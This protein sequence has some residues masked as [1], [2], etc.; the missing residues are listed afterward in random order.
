ME[1]ETTAKLERVSLSEQRNMRYEKFRT[2]IRML[3]AKEG[4]SGCEASEKMNPST[5]NAETDDNT[6]RRVI[7]ISK[8][9]GYGGFY[10]MN[11]FAYIST[12]PDGLVDVSPG[13][14]QKN[15][16]YIEYVASRCSDVVFAWGS[17]SVVKETGRDKELIEMFPNAKALYINKNGSPKH[18]LFC[19]AETKFIDFK[20]KQ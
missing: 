16:T 11:C 14:R 20:I 1:K 3:R 15:D 6:I 5:A 7:E 10:M 9:N 18:P 17:F 13:E 2:N 19:K 12:N 8:Y 4:L